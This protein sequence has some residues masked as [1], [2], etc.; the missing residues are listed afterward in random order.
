MINQ[1]K[2]KKTIINELNNE[3]GFEDMMEEGPLVLTE[4]DVYEITKT[5]YGPFQFVDKTEYDLA[6]AQGRV[7]ADPA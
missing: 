3:F 4:E 2:K 1:E 5:L 6:I 7:Q